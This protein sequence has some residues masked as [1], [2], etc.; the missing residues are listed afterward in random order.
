MVS[1]HWR[2]SALDCNFQ[3]WQNPSIVVGANGVDIVLFDDRARVTMDKPRD[4]LSELPNRYWRQGR[5]VRIEEGGL[6]APN[7]DDLIRRNMQQTKQIVES[8][9]IQIKC[10]NA[11]VTASLPPNKSLDR[12][13]GCAF[14]II[15]D[16]ARRD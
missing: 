9:G 16:P 10:P 2:S 15:I 11:H 8:L 4:Y 6:R 12:S 13:G 5:I 1:C 7:A 3:D 14:C